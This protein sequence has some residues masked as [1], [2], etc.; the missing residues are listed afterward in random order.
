M[1]THKEARI[2]QRVDHATERSGAG[3][4]VSILETGST[5]EAEFKAHG[6]EQ[7]RLGQIAG[8]VEGTKRED[9]QRKKVSSCICSMNHSDKRRSGLDRERIR[10]VSTE[11]TRIRGA[12]GT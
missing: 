11:Q 6:Y 8:E 4:E 1:I 9:R 2:S 5:R 10:L 12:V 3:D 7:L